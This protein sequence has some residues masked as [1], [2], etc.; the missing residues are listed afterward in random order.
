MSVQ[1]MKFP[2]IFFF[3]MSSHHPGI[4]I[5]SPVARLLSLSLL[6][7]STNLWQLLLTSVAFGG[8]EAMWSGKPSSFMR[9]NALLREESFLFFPPSW[10]WWKT[11]HSHSIQACLHDYS[12]KQVTHFGWDHGN[13]WT[14][15]W[16]L[17]LANVRLPGFDIATA[18]VL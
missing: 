5:S 3:F 8:E 11:V 14:A 9:M 18:Q 10:L 15:L 6:I 17:L 2:W 7:S 4:S 16:L 13:C 12:V 1:C